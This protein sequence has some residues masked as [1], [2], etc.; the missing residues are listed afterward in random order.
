MDPDHLCSH[1]W[2]PW[3]CLFFL[4]VSTTAPRIQDGNHETVWRRNWCWGPANI[5]YGWRKP[6]SRIGRRGGVRAQTWTQM[7]ALIDNCPVSTPAKTSPHAP[8]TLE[9]YLVKQQWSLFHQ[10]NICFGEPPASSNCAPWD[11]LWLLLLRRPL[12]QRSPRWRPIWLRR[13]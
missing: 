10:A 7:G 5:Q 6:H 12:I 13:N 3:T 8:C 11:V 1:G 4:P 2:L 9:P